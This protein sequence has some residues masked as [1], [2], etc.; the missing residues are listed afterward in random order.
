MG[1]SFTSLLLLL[2]PHQKSTNT[3]DNISY[4]QSVNNFWFTGDGTENY[5]INLHLGP[6]AFGTAS[7]WHSNSEISN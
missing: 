5:S 4:S 3:G 7:I 2:L 6:F 1:E